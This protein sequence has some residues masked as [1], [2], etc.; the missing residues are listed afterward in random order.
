MSVD[1]VILA[2][3]NGSRMKSSTPKFFQT[4][5]G[6][7][8]IRYIIDTCKLAGSGSQS[9]IFVVTRDELKCS[10]NFKDINT[11]VQKKPLGT[12]N[13]VEQVFEHLTSEDVVILCGDMPLVEP[14][15]LEDLINAPAENAMIAMT[16]PDELSQM[17][18]GR[19]IQKDGRFDKIV[20]Y[21]NATDDEKKVNLANT[22]VY[23]IK[24]SLLKKYLPLIK[25]NPAANE[26][27]LTDIFEIMKK[28]NV[29]ISVIE[30]VDYWPFHGINTMQD[31]ARAEAIMQSKLRQDFMD[32]GVR[33]I[34]PESVHFSHD[35]KIEHDVVIEPNVFIGNNVKIG[36][37]SRI[38]AFSHIVDCEIMEN[39]EIG[40]F[41]RIR[42]NSI[43]MNGS[44]I[45]NFVEVKGSAF[46][47][48]TKSKH[49]AYIGDTNIG[50]KTN[51][52]AGTITCNYDGVK[53]YRTSIGNEV[54]VGSNSTLVAPV[55]I[56][57]G[58][59]IGAGSVITKD[60]QKGALAISRSPQTQIP[61]GAT[62][63]WKSKG[64]I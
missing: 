26:F 19:V 39:V 44:S 10:E 2:A 48:N 37:G 25:K 40:P 30:S 61:D 42:G 6:K 56:E 18:Y 50:N 59:I 51:I 3:G 36:R 16:I 21:K 64:K 54:F 45:G 46:G 58:S 47:E 15:H 8:V 4:I 1:F 27:Y 41:A 53:K 22:G 34:E 24:T 29:E 43:F 17:P 35:T 13:A 60:V 38:N 28:D 32:L 52:G 55:T 12:A 11:V 31:L 5:A 23:K 7:P 57:D 14:R 63:I 9:S 33:L 62:K 20:E 49:L